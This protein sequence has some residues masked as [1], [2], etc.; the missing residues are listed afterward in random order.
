MR[1]RLPLLLIGAAGLAAGPAGAQIPSPR[2]NSIFPP[3]ARQGSTVEC[4]VAGGELDG[5]TGLHFSAKGVSAVPAGANKFK[6]TVAADCPVGRCDVR[7]ITPQGLSNFRTFSISDRNEVVEKE[8]NNDPAQAVRLT[9]PAVANGVMNG[10]TDVDHFVFSAKAGERIILDCRAQRID[11]RLDGTLMVFDSAGRELAYAGD[12]FGRDPFLDFTAPSDGDYVVRIWDFTYE[13]GGDLF[14]RLEVGSAPHVDA[15]I[16]PAVPPGRKS[17]VTLLGRNLP[18]GKPCG[19]TVGGRPL[20]SLTVEVS[21]PAVGDV[22][23]HGDPLRPPATGL[24]GFEY[25]L[26]SKAGTG[27]P[28]FIGLTDL[29]VVAEAEPNDDRSAPQRLTLPCEVAG[30]FAKV[31]DVDVFAVTLKKGEA[32]VAEIIAERQ[33]GLPDPFLTGYDA[34]GK[35]LT[36]QDDVGRNIGRLRFTTTTRDSRWDFT[37]PADGEY[38]VA[39]RDLYFQQRGDARFTYRLSLRRPTPDFRLVAVP[40]HEIQPD[41]TVLRRGGS[42]KLD[43]L[44]FR[45]DGFDG[46]VTVE[47][48]RLPTGVSGAPVVIGPGKTSA[49]LVFTAAADAPD[50]AGAIELVGTAEIAGRPV[51]RIARAGGLVWPTVNTPGIARMADEV[52]LAVRSA[53][54]FALSAAPARIEAAPGSKTTI[55]VKVSRA[56]HWNDSVQLSAYDP[57][58]GATVPLATVGKGAADGKVVLEIPADAKPGTYSFVVQGAGQV[59]R[60]YGRTRDPKKPAAGNVRVLF[61]APAITVT[62]TAPGK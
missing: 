19:Q 7:V 13:G 60:D 31:G 37:A 3:G 39:V 36:G 11:S 48:R 41:G 33:S 42:E 51:A 53:P 59:P 23:G 27:N 46:P 54:P 12:V 17:T 20:E 29:P 21:A 16:P 14:Y 58:P 62:V 40:N 6:V 35:R 56:A 45:N 4:T 47:A 18:G 22:L 2:L 1:L 57:P 5:A 26:A 32:F 25:R 43:V 28:V 34:K 52:A 50:W 9:L 24:D 55:A 61:P 10:G 30:S 49:P 44:L 38:F 8:P 15:V